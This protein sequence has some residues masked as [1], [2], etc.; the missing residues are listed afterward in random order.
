MQVGI[1]IEAI[2]Y[3]EEVA[4]IG[5]LLLLLACGVWDRA[6]GSNCLNDMEEEDIGGV[7]NVEA[8]TFG[9]EA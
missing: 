6:K 9:G 3:I 1:E 2:D 4:L 5:W 8:S 7:S